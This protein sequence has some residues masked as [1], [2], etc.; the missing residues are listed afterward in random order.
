[1]ITST[2]RDVS[3]IAVLMA[4]FLF[5]Y[6]LIGMELFAY[7]VPLRTLPVGQHQPTFNTLLDAFLSVFIV[8][9]NDGWVS[10]YLDHYR[11]TNSYLASG[12]FISLLIM[13]QLILLNLFISIL[14]E[15]FE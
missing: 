10:L 9:A 8:L 5:I 15:N 3:N 12:F 13:S 4:L 1:V 2:L 6:M 11:A 7:K 14:I